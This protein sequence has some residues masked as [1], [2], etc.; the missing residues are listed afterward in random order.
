MN[1]PE[2]TCG[3]G[4][5]AHS[6]IDYRDD[7]ER[8]QR[9]DSPDWVVVCTGGKE[10]DSDDPWD[11]VCGCVWNGSGDPPFLGSLASVRT[12]HSAEATDPAWPYLSHAYYGKAFPVK[13]G[14]VKW[15]EPE[16]VAGAF[17]VEP[18]HDRSWLLL[19]NGETEKKCWAV[20]GNAMREVTLAWNERDFRE[21]MDRLKDA[22]HEAPERWWE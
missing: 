9:L 5:E 13:Y 14:V 22:H 15:D 16:T 11:H 7:L 20:V 17:H 18:S 19:F 8:N 6:V 12:N 1:H 2:C 4:A 21:G 10:T 3:H